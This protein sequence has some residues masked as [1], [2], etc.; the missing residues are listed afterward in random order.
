MML[1]ICC[2]I[3]IQYSEVPL[4]EE[5]KLL[6]SEQLLSGTKHTAGG[7]KQKTRGSSSIFSLL[8]HRQ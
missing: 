3:T 8:N 5:H 7:W 2:F 4:N 1:I 6:W